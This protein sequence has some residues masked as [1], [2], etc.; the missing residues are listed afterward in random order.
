M[1]V[2]DLAVGGSMS[3]YSETGG[4]TKEAFQ[5]IYDEV[6]WGP[7]GGGSGLGSSLEYTQNVRRLLQGVITRYNPSPWTLVPSP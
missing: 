3:S 7:L 6:L 2:T 1:T 5:H 4:A